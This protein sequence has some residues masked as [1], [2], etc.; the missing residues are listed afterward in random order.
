MNLPAVEPGHEVVCFDFDGVLAEDTWPSP[1]LGRPIKEGVTL[2]REY[3]KAG[4][5]VKIYTARPDSHERLIWNWLDRNNLASKV[6]DVVCNKPISGLYFD[7][8]A[9]KFNREDYQ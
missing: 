7:D 2:L 8:R 3:V 6:Y 4:Y 9:V 5:A 1:V